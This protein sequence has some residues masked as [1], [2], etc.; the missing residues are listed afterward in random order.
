[1]IADFLPSIYRLFAAL[2]YAGRGLDTLVPGLLRDGIGERFI[3]QAGIL[4]QSRLQL[5][6][7]EK[8][9]GRG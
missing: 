5:D 4:C 9:G 6:Q 7:F 2:A 3:F 8:I 1:M